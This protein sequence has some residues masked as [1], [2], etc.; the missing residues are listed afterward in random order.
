MGV[1]S[2]PSVINPKLKP[3]QQPAGLALDRIEQLVAAYLRSIPNLEL[4]HNKYESISQTLAPE[5]QTISSAIFQSKVELARPAQAKLKEP[6]RSALLTQKGRLDH[7]FQATCRDALV[8]CERDVDNSVKSLISNLANFSPTYKEARFLNSGDMISDTDAVDLARD[9]LSGSEQP[10]SSPCTSRLKIKTRGATFTANRY[11]VFETHKRKRDGAFHSSQKRPRLESTRKSMHYDAV[12]QNSRAVKKHIIVRRPEDI[13]R[14]GRYYIIRCDRHNVS[15]EDNPLQ[16]ASTHLQMKHKSVDAFTYDSVIDHL[17]CEVIGC[18]DEKLEE[19]NSLARKAF[20]R[21]DEGP[22]GDNIRVRERSHSPEPQQRKKHSVQSL[23][24]Y[25]SKGRRTRRSKRQTDQQNDSSHKVDLIP[26]KVYISYW[27]ESKQWFAGVLLPLQDL[28]SIGIHDSME[29]IGLLKSLPDCYQYDSSAMSFSWTKGY[30]DGGPMSSE[31]HFAFA[32]FEG[33]KFPEE[34]HLA[35]IPIHDIKEWDEKQAQMIEHSEQALDYLKA[36]EENKPQELGSNDEIRDSAEG[37][38]CQQCGENSPTRCLVCTDSEDDLSL[39]GPQSP[40]AESSV[41]PPPARN[42]DPVTPDTAEEPEPSELEQLRKEELHQEELRQEELRQEEIRQEEIRQEEMRQ[43]EMRQEELRQEELRKIELRREAAAEAEEFFRQQTLREEQDEDV[44]MDTQEDDTEAVPIIIEGES[45]EEAGDALQLQED[46]DKDIVKN[47]QEETVESNPERRNVEEHVVTSG[48]VDETDEEMVVETQESI[49]LTQDKDSA[50][51]NEVADEDQEMVI[52]TRQNNSD[53]SAQENESEELANASEKGEDVEKMEEHRPQMFVD[54]PED[55]TGDLPLQDDPADQSESPP[56]EPSL[57][58]RPDTNRLSSADL[59]NL[60]SECEDLEMHMSQSELPKRDESRSVLSTVKPAPFASMEID[61]LDSEQNDD[62]TPSPLAD[63]GLPYGET[64]ERLTSYAEMCKKA[65]SSPHI[66]KSSQN[67]RAARQGSS[68]APRPDPK[69]PVSEPSA[70]QERAER[71]ET[72]VQP[73]TPT[74]TFSTSPKSSQVQPTT[75]VTA[76]AKIPFRGLR[77]PESQM[78]REPAPRRKLPSHAPPVIVQRLPLVSASP[79]QSLV[80]VTP[81][82]IGYLQHPHAQTAMS[83]QQAAKDMH[84][85]VPAT[86]QNPEPVTESPRRS[87]FRHDSTV[88]K[89]LETQPLS[90]PGRAKAQALY[91]P[92]VT[93]DY[94]DPQ[95]LPS[96]R[97][98]PQKVPGPNSSYRVMESKD[99]STAIFPQAPTMSQQ[100]TSWRASSYR[101][102]SIQVPQYMSIGS[103]STP[104]PSPTQRELARPES[105]ASDYPAPQSMSPPQYPA[106]TQRDSPAPYQ[107]ASHSM[108]SPRIA[109]MSI[110]RPG[111]VILCPPPSQTSQPPS[112]R[113]LAMN[114][115]RPGS[116]VQNTAAPQVM[117]SP[118]QSAHEVPW[119]STTVRSPSYV[120]P[121]Q[122][123]PELPRPHSQAYEHPISQIAASPRQAAM[124]ISRSGSTTPH[125]VPH[126]TPS[127]RL[128]EMELARP[129]TFDYRHQLPLMASPRPAP[130]SFSRSGSVVQANA[131]SQVRGLPRATMEPP[132]PNSMA[133][134]VP[135]SP[136]MASPQ[137]M[138]SSLSRPDSTRQEYPPLQVTDSPIQPSMSLPRPNTSH[139]QMPSSPYQAARSLHRPRTSLDMQYPP[140]ASS[141]QMSQTGFPLTKPRMSN[142]GSFQGGSLPLPIPSANNYVPTAPEAH[143]SSRPRQEPV[144]HTNEARRH[145]YSASTAYD[146]PYS[147]RSQSQ[148]VE[149]TPRSY[150]PAYQPANA[151]N[152]NTGPAPLLSSLPP[153][154]ADM[155]LQRTGFTWQAHPDY[156]PSD[157]INYEG[158][159]QCPFCRMRMSKAGTFVDHLQKLCP[160][161]DKLSQAK[162]PR[163]LRR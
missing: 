111:S 1:Q 34:S 57:P 112:P 159:Y 106:A 85:Q 83:Q 35:W 68:I 98:S 69:H 136:M 31:Q 124:S 4:S 150:Q 105:A 81:R 22:I 67:Q 119:P 145:S 131:A 47:M 143:R 129:N 70:L 120:S 101:P 91:P 62:S 139:G 64:P 40:Q 49:P 11:G 99:P 3:T 53:N 140:T 135:R 117:P 149:S 80:D 142:R 155:L 158:Q 7:D 72:R 29:K 87:G 132:Q 58:R 74:P 50:E 56:R 78:T 42:N 5:I 36:Q 138:A 12:Y 125:L 122:H 96:L 109:A 10:Q 14:P 6:E 152:S 137:Q 2:G 19:N 26:G 71:S 39:R 46:K 51:V 148:A 44:I 52:D 33:V 88:S 55:T 141:P 123:I 151:K 104:L 116:V 144:S 121:Y 13:S 163:A 76:P 20:K 118:R 32:F 27:T 161:T 126:V 16:A 127:P 102:N 103:A 66:S 147:Y 153:H 41:D 100:P 21:G 160:S 17:G 48:H 113:R 146:Q 133:Y 73:E 94:S 65:S 95:P 114:I 79:R 108:A 93:G 77:A 162:K 37:K 130:M 9:G 43:E 134:G 24:V 157:F 61:A 45:P 110:S 8:A 75:Q 15:F 90:S 92:L 60:L 154:I 89:N 84:R 23:K 38:F 97:Q 107:T 28:E 128:T 156:Q 63:I 59:A 30:E 54:T 25:G 86:P 82:N 115:S 18:D